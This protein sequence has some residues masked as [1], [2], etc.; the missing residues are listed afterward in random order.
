MNRRNFIKTIPAIGLG[1]SVM[2]HEQEFDTRKQKHVKPTPTEYPYY[3]NCY[4][5]N[6]R[7]WPLEEYKGGS[8]GER[9]FKINQSACGEK[10][11]DGKLRFY[12]FGKAVEFIDMHSLV[13]PFKHEIAYEVFHERST[14]P[15]SVPKHIFNYWAKLNTT[16]ER[17]K[18]SKWIHPD[19]IDHTADGALIEYV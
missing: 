4:I 15:L 16:D 17:L 6:Q 7:Y 19:Y 10:W 1:A 8:F 14:N 13:V 5:Q 3:V 9:S 12:G 11:I 2:T 18:E